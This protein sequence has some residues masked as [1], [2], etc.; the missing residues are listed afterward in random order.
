MAGMQQPSAGAADT[1]QMG[2]QVTASTKK[3]AEVQD[4]DSGA[5]KFGD[6]WN[7][8]M[9]QNGGAFDKPR[10][11]KKT[12]GKDDF[13]KLM[14]TQMKYQDPSKPFEM[15]K[16]GSE[17]AQLSN[18]EQ[19]QNLNTTLKQMVTK[20]QPLERLAMTN[21]IG[22]SVV[23]DRDR[24]PHTEGSTE[25]LHFSLPQDA[26]QVSVAVV[27][28]SG[29]VL[30]E[31]ELGPQKKGEN[32]FSWDGK[33]ANSLPAKTGDYSLMVRALDMKGTPMALPKNV[34][35]PVVGVSYEGKEPVLLVGSPNSPDK[36]ALKQVVKIIDHGPSMGSLLPGA[37]PISQVG[38]VGQGV[39]PASSG[40]N[41]FTFEKGVGS[42]NVDSSRLSVDAKKALELY[43][44]QAREAA[45]QADGAEGERGFPNGIAEA[46]AEPAGAENTDFSQ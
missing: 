11:A 2:M 4:A 20:D 12:L 23:V 7:K 3:S 42:A 34:N 17:L 26:K 1:G 37:Q 35:A 28:A 22:K 36:I 29:E 46:N 9:A 30:V 16:M 24:F 41:F 6:V 13:L 45:Q 25:A 44:Q 19:L 10:E 38:Q 18:M 40:Q 39:A 27:D 31:Q 14:I 33:K 21:L 43:E 32:G 15:E 8:I 5:P